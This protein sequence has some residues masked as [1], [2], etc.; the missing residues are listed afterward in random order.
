MFGWDPSG[1]IVFNDVLCEKNVAVGNGGC[2]YSTGRSSVNDGTVMHDNEANEGGC[3][4]ESYS[5]RHS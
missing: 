1:T 2:L 3:I 5:I 4:C